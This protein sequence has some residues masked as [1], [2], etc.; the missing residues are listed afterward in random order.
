MGAALA[1]LLR[2]GG[3]TVVVW[4]VNEPADVVCDVADAEAVGR[5]MVAT[6]ER[7]GVPTVVT[8]CAGIGDSAT[9][10]DAS[11]ELWDRV[12]GVNVRGAWLVMQAAA[13]ALIDGGKTGSIVAF[14]SISGRLSDRGMGPYCASKAALDML[15]RVAAAEWGV[16]G[17]RVNAVA[18][19]V[20][21]TPML[22]GAAR[23]PGWL[24]DV[25]GRTPLGRIG[26]PDDVARVALDVHRLDWV[27]GESIAADGGLRLHSPIDS[28]GAVTRAHR[29]G[30][31][32]Q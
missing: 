2:G 25:A 6:L 10:L 22:A 24:D 4:D 12:Y 15:V 13:R 21:D 19:G 32:P 16:H 1:D 29:P 27:T 5:A 23:I 20:T 9:L 14:S 11:P 31:P 7:V 26:R 28:Y 30:P 17:I 18:P 8:V 3:A